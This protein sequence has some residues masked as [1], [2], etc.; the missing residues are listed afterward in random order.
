MAAKFVPRAKWSVGKLS[1]PVHIDV[2]FRYIQ[3]R[4][5]P[6]MNKKG[7]KSGEGKTY[8]LY[9]YDGNECVSVC[10][11]VLINLY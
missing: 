10:V 9:S 6:E 4:Y 7:E 2:I 3:K 5:V 8:Y 11:W 1:F